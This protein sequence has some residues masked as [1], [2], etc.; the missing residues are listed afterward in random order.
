MAQFLEKSRVIAR[1]LTESFDKGWELLS[2]HKKGIIAGDTKVKGYYKEGVAHLVFMKTE[3]GLGTLHLDY[4][5]LK[6]GEEYPE[7][8]AVHSSFEGTRY[9][10]TI[11][12]AQEH[13]KVEC[14][15]TREPATVEFPDG[16]TIS[17][18]SDSR[19]QAYRVLGNRG[20]YSNY[21]KALDAFQGL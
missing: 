8:F 11:E 1:E 21:K 3:E 4:A 13:A 5:L 20:Q 19:G 6:E 15:L 16:K 2:S 14:R 9:F 17:Y 10:D 12:A 7:R 18:C